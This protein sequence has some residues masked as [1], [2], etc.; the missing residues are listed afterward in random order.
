MTS[1]PKSWNRAHAFAKIAH[2][3][4]KRKYTGLP[5]VHH[6]EMVA[7]RMMNLGCSNDVICAAYLHDVVEDTH[8]TEADLRRF[9]S[10]KVCDLVMEVTDVSKP[11]D[12]NRATRK[13]MDR[14][15]LEKASPEA[16]TIKLADLIDNMYDIV[17]HDPNFAKVFMKEA[18]ALVE[19]L[20]NASEQ[21]LWQRAKWM[22]EE[23]HAG[24]EHGGDLW[25]F[26]WYEEDAYDTGTLPPPGSTKWG[27]A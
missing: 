16:K 10:K 24:P 23:W 20:W 26:Y 18:E 3:E 11:E 8:T 4:Q 1:D 2:G 21:S 5:Y 9:F 14:Q 15:H 13:E 12:G 25:R 27:A 6:C 19:A 17:E 22:I 7:S